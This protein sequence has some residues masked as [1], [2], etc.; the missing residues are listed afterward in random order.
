MTEDNFYLTY[1]GD[2]NRIFYMA[3]MAVPPNEAELLADIILDSKV[4]T[5]AIRIDKGHAYG[6][7]HAHVL[8]GLGNLLGK[9]E[10][11]RKISL[12]IAFDSAGILSEVFPYFADNNPAIAEFLKNYDKG[13][14]NKEGILASLKASLHGEIFLKTR[15]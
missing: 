9:V 3:S 13:M 15:G 1:A 2:V 10:P 6:R 11:E 7:D 14:E 12:Y 8:R 5:H 4:F